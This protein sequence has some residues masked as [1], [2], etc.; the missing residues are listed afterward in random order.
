MLGTR[1]LAGEQVSCKALGASCELGRQLLGTSWLVASAGGNLRAEPQSVGGI[2]GPALIWQWSA[3]PW[4]QPQSWHL[5][6]QLT[7][8]LPLLA[9]EAIVSRLVTLPVNLA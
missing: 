3:C 8:L 6:L 4:K 5:Q 7:V 9:V 1:L 2:S